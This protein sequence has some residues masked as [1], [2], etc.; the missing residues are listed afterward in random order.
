MMLDI[1]N[2]FVQTEIPLDRDKI[3][4]KIRGKLVN[5]LL[6]FV[7]ECVINISGMKEGRRFYTYG[8]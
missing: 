1:T 6:K 3:I 4:M 2:E 8:C 7:Q 5:I